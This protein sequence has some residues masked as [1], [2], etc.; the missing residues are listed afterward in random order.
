MDPKMIPW[1]RTITLIK[2]SVELMA[3][4]GC[5]PKTLHLEAKDTRKSSRW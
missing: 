2:F 1:E 4:K 3:E 5:K